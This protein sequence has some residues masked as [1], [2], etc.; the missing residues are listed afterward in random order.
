MH[1]QAGRKV[2]ALTGV[3]W[4]KGEETVLG[5]KLSVLVFFDEAEDLSALTSAMSEMAKKY[6]KKISIAGL[7]G[8]SEESME[9]VISYT[10]EIIQYGLGIVSEKL[11]MSY[12][13]GIEGFSSAFVID[14]E[15]HLLWNGDF[16]SMDTALAVVFK[17]KDEKILLELGKKRQK[18]IEL[19]SEIQ[20][21]ISLHLDKKKELKD[22]LSEYLKVFADDDDRM[23]NLEVLYSYWTPGEIFS[24]PDQIDWVSEKP[25]FQKPYSLVSFWDMENAPYVM[26][27][28]HIAEIFNQ[29]KDMLNVI[30][31]VKKT[32]SKEEIKEYLDGLEYG[33]DYPTGII[34]EKNFQKILSEEPNYSQYSFLTDGENR[35]LWAGTADNANP[36]ILYLKNH[37]NPDKALLDMQADKE[38]FTALSNAVNAGTEITDGV[39]SKIRKYAK[40]ILK[41]NPEDRTVIETVLEISGILGSEQLKE[42]F[43]EIEFSEIKPEFIIDIIST[44]YGLSEDIYPFEYAFLWLETA[45]KK[46]P[47][48]NAYMAY[49]N[50]LA[51]AGLTQT[52]LDYFN[53]ALEISSDDPE[54]EIGKKEMLRIL[55]GQK[56]ARR[57]SQTVK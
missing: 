36:I 8:M 13:A 49:G 24:L 46:N 38:V 37:K 25:D 45:L 5:E 27:F 48:E 57:V 14:S 35:L 30:S 42:T 18:I 32:D 53:K 21:N 20:G 6:K 26:P 55:E 43:S 23:E 33:T 7:S 22:L 54:A 52:A 17:K 12:M 50:V 11:D 41:V 29:H 56:S 3:K 10:E 51:K 40:K 44:L 39:L 2:P 1:L 16:Q 15:K 19:N 9:S 31:L 47:N 4:I 34:S 28:P